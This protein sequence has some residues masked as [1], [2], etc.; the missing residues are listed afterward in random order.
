MPRL[1]A[2]LPLA[3]PLA[4]LAQEPRLRA[5]SLGEALETVRR[6]ES[7][8]RL[9]REPDL[10][11]TYVL[12]ERPGQNQVS[13]YD[14]RWR[15]LDLPAPG[16]GPG[17]IRL[18]FY[19]SARAQ[20]RRAL[21]AIRSAYARL[22]DQFHFNPTRR[23]PFILYG[24][25]REFQTTNVFQVTESVLGV[26][27]PED[28][29]M[30]VPYFGDH[31]RFVEV[32]TH[33]MVHQFTIQKLLA[34]TGRSELASPIQFLP[35]WFIEGIAEYYTKG[36]IDGETDLFLR[37]LVWNPDARRR[38]EV[39]PFAEDQIR[40]YIPT[41]KLGQ[42]RIAFIAEAY[43]AEKIQSFLESAYLL[44]ESARSGEPGPGPGG[45]GFT[46]LVNRILGEPIEQVDARWKAWL[47][48]RYYAEYLRAPQDLGEV[49][50]LRGLPAEPE[51]FE[52]SPD[53][54]VLVARTI[55]RERG[56]ARIHLFEPRRP[57]RAIELG[58]DGSPA[59][60]SLHPVDYGVLAIG[61][62]LVGF[63]AQSGPGDVFYLATWERPRRQD[64]TPGAVQVGRRKRLDLRAPDGGTFVQIAYPTFSPDGKELAFAGVG[65]DGQQD[66]YVAPIGGGTARR[67]TNDPYTEK[68]LAWGPEGILCASDATDHAR[69]NLFRIDPATGART[70]LTT[71]PAEDRHPRPQP[72][73]S[74]L[75]S[76][77]AAGKPDLYR[78]ADGRV[79]RL[80][81]FTTGLTAPA[82][83]AQGRGLLAG[84]FHGGHFR[85]VEVPR[86]A[87]LQPQPVAVPPAA[88]PPLPLPEATLPEDAPVYEPY[89]LRNW[90]PEAGFVYAGG[91]SGGYAGRGAALFAD[92]LRDRILFLDVAVWGSFDFTQA[93]ALFED[94]SHR[95][96]WSAGAFHFVQEQIDTLDPSLTFNQRD[97]GVF[98]A[99]RYPFDR[100]R[101]VE[102]D[103]T[104]GATQRECLTDW[105]GIDLVFCEGIRTPRGDGAPWPDTQAW[106]EANGGLS[107]VVSAS[108]RFGRDTL[109]Y[110]P[111]TGPLSGTSF[112]AEVGGSWIPSKS[113][114]TG[115][116][117]LDAQRFF[118]IAGRANL[119]L[120]ASA[121]TSFSPGGASEPWERI[122]W[123]VPADN[124]RG[125][126]PGDLDFLQG[127]HYWVTNA[128]LQVP[129]SPIL[130]LVIFDY[131]EGVAALDFGAVFNRFDQC[132][133]PITLERLEP[134]YWGSRTL[135]GV[136]GVNVLLGPILLR[137]HFGHPYDVDGLTTPALF[138]GDE[139]VTN[140]TLRYFFW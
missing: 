79:Q 27:S 127:R 108:A 91:A 83:S 97:F 126:Y 65:R 28:L 95:T 137:V 103:L 128:E 136:L 135:T 21:P 62:G 7:E 14:F 129:L 60:E 99:V 124:L 30:T 8:P 84:T 130:R 51:A 100:F 80:T 32:A 115:F 63:S 132:Q 122:W 11:Q 2:L 125:F 40:G 16:G 102:A 72:D 43:G 123:I 107:F 139:W 118:Q 70:R 3:L 23:I 113:A 85:L 29:R 9:R 94:R 39:L 46:A 96:V 36:G 77:D 90:R 37:D 38:Y 26:T 55:D 15:R 42:A 78:L 69:L 76:S 18:Y 104:L 138:F 64:G 25:Q 140:I 121:G 19:D 106:E 52:A 44:G 48:R 116:A 75:F 109:R 33:E 67:V 57:R 31:A 22:V 110:H 98:G 24:T 114:V 13:W 134:C 105:A 73:G 112:L 101:R 131:I 68:D 133:D 10:E 74:V 89:S 86:A 61:D 53:G 81:D 92:Y 82:A 56:R 5:P 49:K 17:G 34:E 88:G 71:A 35:L 20:A 117:R 45:R 66:V 41:Y 59:V 120:R 119:M 87:L 50:E 12:P 4:A 6:L 1:L 111:G 47:K 93:L 58:A 54:A